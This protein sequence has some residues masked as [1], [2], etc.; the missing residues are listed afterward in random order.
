MKTRIAIICLAAAAVLGL[1][2]LWMATDTSGDRASTTD[3]G[4]AQSGLLAPFDLDDGHYVIVAS[5]GEAA[6][7]NHPEAPLVRM[8]DNQDLISRF[9]SEIDVHYGLTDFLPGEGRPSD[10]Y[11]LVY[12]NGERVAGKRITQADRI[13]IPDALI[14]AS[15][16]VRV[17]TFSGFRKDY[18]RERERLLAMGALMLDQSEVTPADREYWASARLPTVTVAPAEP[19]DAEAYADVVADRIRKALPDIDF[20]L[21][22]TLSVSYPEGRIILLDENTGLVRRDADGDRVQL[23][24]VTLHEYYVYV[25]GGPD[26]HPAFEKLDLASF[27]ADRHDESLVLQAWQESTGVDPLPPVVQIDGYRATASLGRP[28]RRT[29]SL[30]WIDPQ[31]L[32]DVPVD[33]E[34]RVPSAGR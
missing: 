28:E 19:F 3:S 9:R 27:V 25:S 33:A 12:R 6:L 21:S 30:T 32:V 14:E 22:V 10:I 1:L 2:G 26:I 23:S 13:K 24:G 17:R 16:L 20:D 8:I 31:D 11:L 5:M 29:Y 4:T 34:Q 7:R 18:L 15:R